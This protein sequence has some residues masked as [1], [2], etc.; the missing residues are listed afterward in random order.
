MAV[1][2]ENGASKVSVMTIGHHSAVTSGLANGAMVEC[3]LIFPGTCYQPSWVA[4]NEDG[5]FAYPGLTEEM[6]DNITFIPTACGVSTR[7][8]M[9][10]VLERIAEA[11]RRALFAA[12]LDLDPAS[13]DVCNSGKEHGGFK[14]S[15]IIEM[16]ACDSHP[17][18][19]TTYEV[20]CPLALKVRP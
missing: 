14:Y 6:M 12:D 2:G 3:M 5:T 20:N 10:E 9:A 8:S 15:M 18:H 19:G 13:K 17:F 16:D 4:A 1:T 7:Q 11:K